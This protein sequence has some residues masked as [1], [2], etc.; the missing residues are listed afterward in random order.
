MSQKLVYKSIIGS[1]LSSIGNDGKL[2]YSLPV[3]HQIVL[4]YCKDLDFD[5][6]YLLYRFIHETIDQILLTKF[7]TPFKNKREEMTHLFNENS[8][9]NAKVISFCYCIIKDWQNW[10][11]I[12]SL[13]DSVFSILN[14]DEKI[15]TVLGCTNSIVEYGKF[16]FIEAYFDHRDM[17]TWP[18]GIEK[19]SNFN[20]EFEKNLK[21]IRLTYH[22]LSSLYVQE[23]YFNGNPE[24]IQYLE[25]YEKCTRFF[26]EILPISAFEFM[27]AFSRDNISASLKNLKSINIK[28]WYK[29]H[30]SHDLEKY[31]NLIEEEILYN[32]EISN[33]YK[34]EYLVFEISLVS[35]ISKNLEFTF[36]NLLIKEFVF[37][38]ENQKKLE[39]VVKILSYAS[40][41]AGANQ[42]AFLK[43][44]QK[45][46]ELK[47][48]NAI[49]QNSQGKADIIQSISFILSCFEHREL[50]QNC[51]LKYDL[52]G[53]NYDI[54][55]FLFEFKMSE[56]D[57]LDKPKIK[58]FI[59][60]IILKYCDLYFKFKEKIPFATF[61]QTVL[62]IYDYSD[63]FIAQY[64]K[65]LSRRLL[66]GKKLNLSEERRVVSLF[67]KSSPAFDSQ[68]PMTLIDDIEFAK[69]QQVS[70]DSNGKLIDFKSLLLQRDSWRDIPDESFAHLKI[71]QDMQNIL[72]QVSQKKFDKK[73]DW[74]HYKLH[75]LSITGQFSNNREIIINCNLL[76]AIIILSFNKSDKL[77]INQLLNNFN[78]ESNLL[79]SILQTFKGNS[80]ILIQKN[81]TILFNRKFKN[82]SGVV[83]LPP[84]KNGSAKNSREVSIDKDTTSN[85]E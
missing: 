20:E 78:M 19:I 7:I 25:A 43:Q 55:E 37:I 75:K 77:S 53:V 33:G 22:E 82:K 41:T 13:C 29:A 2:N 60:K 61:S 5:A 9:D 81:D 18:L 27:V 63:E 54:D 31:L 65:D 69:T 30:G 28:G 14:K 32:E 1:F 73:L 8:I 56:R 51:I 80:N 83:N 64:T 44:W 70:T 26:A 6:L 46:H 84:I 47:F 48:D 16:R 72:Q 57:L 66:L 42:R 11:K 15:N 58:N 67:T 38:M 36:E 74:S 68:R 40:T 10:L 50:L 45:Y 17:K 49:L 59:S 39:R 35:A 62:T 3:L 85:D 71:P 79:N 52:P 21:L 12:I 4:G 23:K 76:Q 24:N 34:N